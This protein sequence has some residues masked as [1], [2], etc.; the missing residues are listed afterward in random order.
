LS[1][2]ELGDILRRDSL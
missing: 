2:Q 1:T